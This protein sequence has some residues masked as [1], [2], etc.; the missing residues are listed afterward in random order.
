MTNGA[1]GPATAVGAP[2][3]PAAL[4]GLRPSEVRD[5][6]LL[7]GTLA[8]LVLVDGRISSVRRTEDRTTR[9]ATAPD[10]VVLDATGWRYVPAASEPHAH[11]DKALT[12]ART[13]PDAG[14]DLPTAI[15]QWRA[16][17]PGIDRADLLDRARAAVGTYV[18]NG[19]TSIRTHVDALLDGD[20]LR[21]VDALVALREELAGVI[22][23]Q[24]CLLAGQD[25][26][27]DV[28]RE[29]IARGVDV[30][31][32]CPHL[33]DDPSYQ[34][35]RALDLAEQHGLPV[36]L[37]TDEQTDPR[38][39]DLL[40]LAEQVVARGMQQLVT[41]SHCVRLGSL[42]SARLAPVLDAVAAAGIGIV[43]LPITNL[44]LQGWDVDGVVPRGLPNLRAILDAGIPLA[45]GADNLRDPF[46]PV[47]RADPF[48][49]TSLL[50]TA[51]HL[52]VG[53]SLAAVTTGA[54]TVLGLPQVGAEAGCAADFLLVPDV[55]VADVLAGAEAARVVLHGGRVVADTRVSRSL[56]LTAGST[57]TRSLTPSLPTR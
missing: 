3:G 35:R 19:I 49:T 28:I 12:W 39:I 8:D 27:T 4:S 20:P 36:D 38:S 53:E 33:A 50:V 7:D 24:V 51:G 23:L 10:A 15:T 22:D 54:R 31:G 34:T 44:Y 40:D 13:D 43:T 30:V 6:R 26:A 46:N 2:H 25:T 9:S 29:G 41:A 56:D 5:V 55:P 11:L 1:Y 32:G 21:G 16:L 48:E 47:G 52:T 45:A 17:V 57:A 37:H 18:A 42:T 14:N